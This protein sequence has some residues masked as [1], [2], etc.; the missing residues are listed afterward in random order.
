[1]QVSTNSLIS[2]LRNFALPAAGAA[3]LVLG[4]ALYLNHNAIHV[5]A[6]SAA[7][8][9][10]DQSVSSLVSLDNA[11]EAVARPRHARRRQRLRHRPRLARR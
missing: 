1:M 7:A 9:L 11:I 8:P 4:G 10:D 2:K 3:A 6:A 5:H